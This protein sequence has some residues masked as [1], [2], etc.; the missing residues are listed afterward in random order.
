MP[1]HFDAA[2]FDARL[3]R[4]RA[5][6]DAAELD[7]ILLF[8]PESHFWLT[9]YD[10]FGFAMFQCMVLGAKSRIASSSSKGKKVKQ[11]RV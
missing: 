10:T 1:I 3:T 6:L 8:A 4:A 5:A 2:E 7:A 9:G 11:E